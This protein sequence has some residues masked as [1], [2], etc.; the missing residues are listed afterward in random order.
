M[1]IDWMKWAE[2][3]FYNAV[4]P[5]IIPIAIVKLFSWL[6]TKA[7]N[8][9]LKIFA[10]IKDGQVFFYC[11]ALTASAFENLRKLPPAFDTSPW[12]MGFVLILILSSAAFALGVIA[13]DN[14]Q[15][16]KFGWSSACMVAAAIFLVITFRN[17]AGLL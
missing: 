17:K 12:L 3:L 16:S 11:T 4:I 14:V 9:P 15:E 5:L 2:W 7:P 8:H 10:I 1:T 13:K 6:V